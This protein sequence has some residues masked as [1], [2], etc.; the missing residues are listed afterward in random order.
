MKTAIEQQSLSFALQNVYRA[1]SPGTTH[2]ILTG[3]LVTAQEGILHF[4]AT[5]L[6][7]SI[8][9]TVPAQVDLPGALVL[10]GR[11]LVE[12]VNRIPGGHI[13]IIA[14][15]DR[16]QAIITWRSSEFVL[17]GYP[18][19]QFPSLPT[20]DEGTSF[21]M[22]ARILKDALGKTAFSAGSGDEV[23]PVICGVRLRFEE[24]DIQTTGTDGFRVA[25]WESSLPGGPDDMEVVLPKPSVTDLLRVIDSLDAE[26]NV[27]IALSENHV[28][29]ETERGVK[30]STVVLEGQYPDVLS[31]VISPGGYETRAVVDR[32]EFT[33][34]CERAALLSEEHRGIR[35]VRLHV[36]RDR[37]V[38][39]ASSAELGEAYDEIEGE[40]EG[41]DL[42]ILFQSRYLLEGIRYMNSDHIVLNFTDFEGAAMIQGQG[43]DLYSY[44]VLPMKTKS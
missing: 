20:A 2:P 1:I 38:F 27:K 33:G 22:P 42:N 35:P 4:S 40:V 43:D 15:E 29:F 14:P 36:M 5:D 25:V 11:E 32:R 23:M 30:F 3:I 28:F 31:M 26:E 34:A 19:D 6:E 39:K 16:H 7:V 9:C 8:E 12:I 13:E 21:S 37:L 44:I 17:N 41:D 10:P 24:G 18:P